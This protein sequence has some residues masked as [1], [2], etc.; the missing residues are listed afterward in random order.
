MK[1]GK[2]DRSTYIVARITLAN[3]FTFPS[4]LP[5]P[6]CLHSDNAA[7]VTA[8]LIIHTL[9]G[10]AVT[11]RFVSSIRM[12][13]R[14]SRGECRGRK[15]E[16]TSCEKQIANRIG[17][18]IRKGDPNDLTWYLSRGSRRGEGGSNAKGWLI[19]AKKKK[20]KGR[21]GIKIETSR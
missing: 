8:R 4:P 7:N 18:G 19:T 16:E 20:K 10:E 17:K 9:C 15:R 13:S 2:Q 14:E 6:M 21:G 3:H 5:P 11:R 1:R 12:Q